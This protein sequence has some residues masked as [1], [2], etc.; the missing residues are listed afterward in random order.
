MGVP[1]EPGVIVLVS[2]RPGHSRHLAEAIRAVARCRLAGPD[3]GWADA[4]SIQGVIADLDLLRPEAERCLRRLTGTRAALPTVLLTRG[5]AV[6]PRAARSAG[7]SLCLPAHTE[8]DAIVE[9][10]VRQIWPNLMVGDLDARRGVARA[11]V[12]MGELFRAAGS[13]PVDMGAVERSLDPVL[14]AIGKGGLLRWLRE[15]WTLDD[16]TFRHCLL[17]AGYVAAFA[18]SLGLSKADQRFM[19]RAGLVHDVGKARIPP[20]ILNKPAAL[21]EAET[22]VMHTHAVIGSDILRVSGGCDPVTLAITRHHHELIDGSGYPDGL[23][24]DEIADP[25]RLLTIC[26]IYSALTER[27]SYKE[28]MAS[29]DALAVLEGMTGK[30]EGGLVQAF[31]KAVNGMP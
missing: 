5:S 16:S 25:V 26:D 30:L 24:G 29:P 8:P 9:A 31:G 4:E 18:R 13:G 19:T 14:D 23:S 3:D 15:V 6:S 21:D 2:D 11:G 7:I 10:L 28:P 12:M 27:R 17:V 20:A 1:M 22:A